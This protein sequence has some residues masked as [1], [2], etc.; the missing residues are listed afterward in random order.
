MFIEI[1]GSVHVLR[2]SLERVE[3]V[4]DLHSAINAAC[5]E[6][7]APELQDLDLDLAQLPSIPGSS[8]VT[9]L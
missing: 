2:V 8:P 5:R 3:C 4:D 9:S 7:R 6:S 1:E